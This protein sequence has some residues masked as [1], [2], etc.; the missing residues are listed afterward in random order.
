MKKNICVSTLAHVDAGKTTLSEAMLYEAGVIKKAGRVDHGDTFMDTDELEKS[1]GITI[2]AKHA[3]ITI[4]DLALFLSDTPGHVDFAPETERILNVCDLALLIIAAESGVTGHTKN[5]FRVI[6]KYSIP[7]IVF[8]NKMDL[9]ASE[10]AA[11]VKKDV[12]ADLNDNLKGNF[13]DF[14]VF[15]TA[16]P[17]QSYGGSFAEDV[18]VSDEA[19]ME[20]YLETGEAKET[21]IVSAVVSSSCYPVLFGSAL[22]GQGVS[23]LLR[24]LKIFGEAVWEKKY[25]GR[26]E[27]PSE[28]EVFKI[29]R[30][31]KN[32][33]LTFVKQLSGVTHVKDMWGDEKINSIRIYN[34][35]RYL[36][37]QELCPGQMGAIPGLINT[38]SEAKSFAFV[39]TMSYGV[40]FPDTYDTVRMMEVFRQLEEE[41]P[42]ISVRYDRSADQI[43]LMLMGEIGTD[44][45]RESVNRR[46]G[47][48]VDFVQGATLYKETIKSPVE[49]VGHY[50]PLRHYAE[51]HLL[52][53]PAERGEGVRVI[54]SK[55]E[56][57]SDETAYRA[58]AAHIGEKEHI[59]TLAGFPIT[60][61][62]IMIL[63][64]RTHEKHTV[65]GDLRQATYRAIRHGLMRS[66]MLSEVKLL[67]PFGRFEAEVPID[68]AGRLISDI[69]NMG[70]RIDTSEGSHITGAAPM[71]GLFGYSQVLS[72]YTSGEG[73][74]DISFLDYE[75][76]VSAQEQ[77]NYDP[78]AD[79]ENDPGSVF[80]SHGA[81]LYVPWFEVENYMHLPWAFVSG[82]A[83]DAKLD[84]AEELE[85]KRQILEAQQRRNAKPDELSYS[86]G[87]AGEKELKQIFERTYGEIK[88]KNI[89]EEEKVFGYGDYEKDKKPEKP[90]VYKPK[91]K[92]GKRLIVD[93][94]NII[95]GW[96]ELKQLSE[97]DI[98]AAR[99]RLCDILDNYSGLIDGDIIVVFD[100]YRIKD[101]AAK[102][103]M[104]GNITI[105]YT[106]TDQT[107]D[108]F[109]E[110][111]V[112]RDGKRLDLTVASS[113][114]MIQT[115]VLG[116]GAL[117]MS[118]RELKSEI[119]SA[120]RKIKE[121]L[122]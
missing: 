1:R 77:A 63:S 17:K 93:G 9:R 91:K 108:A 90:Y 84:E 109:I 24:V 22:K 53:S 98:N 65:G 101:K 42:S 81:G 26:D 122:R 25:K 119:E 44:V 3:L 121:Y 97:T 35:D 68:S 36:N 41:E 34:G 5:L 64:L 37:V 99:M 49:G 120:N 29:G 43:Q 85:R 52:L 78:E 70:G 32:E 103:E 50:E 69:N 116:D 71:S 74:I 118:G 83:G 2:Y 18:S 27:L 104:K 47:I 88:T 23:E 15:A 48:K 31:D 30:D 111:E 7:T 73:S 46:F 80:C 58:V 33:R 76:A 75:D 16:E 62:N 82:E 6:K 40:R 96:E 10:D 87:Y 13:T 19:M 72:G 106:G 60:D 38:K 114:G 8:V 67:E 21:D 102:R 115:M 39:P 57:S 59:G 79:L 117:R 86:A 56:N 92:K 105:V 45:L 20:S 89:Y 61:V 107:A 51:V 100:A 113:D 94:Y 54:Y 4:D 55:P 28:T 112:K 14:S 95:F 66:L 11:V 12:L 110:A